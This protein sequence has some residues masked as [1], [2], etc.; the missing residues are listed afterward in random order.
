MITKEEKRENQRGNCKQG[1]LSLREKQRILQ[2]G[3][4]K[5]LKQE[6]NRE[7]HG[8]IQSI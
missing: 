7:I 6:R 5:Y 2:N 4:G 8:I 3:Q 1:K